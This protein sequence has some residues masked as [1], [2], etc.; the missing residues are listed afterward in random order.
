MTDLVTFEKF[1]EFWEIEPIVVIDS[2]SLLD[3]YRYAPNASKNI[4][5]NLKKIQDNIWLPAHVLEEYFEN[6]ASVISE[7]HKKFENVSKEVQRIVKD[8]EK[9]ITSKFYRYGKFKYPNISTFRNELEEI[10]SSLDEK[11]KSFKEIVTTEIQENKTVLQEDEV[12][13]FIQTLEGLNQIGVSFSLPKKIEIYREGEFRYSHLIPPGYK[14]IDKDSKDPTKTEKFGD[15]IIWK[16]LLDKS[17]EIQKPFI[18]ITDDEKEDWWELKVHNTHLGE[19]KEILGPR[20]ELVSEFNAVSKIGKD[21]FIMLTL[22]EFNKHISK[23]NEVNLKE[24]FLNDIELNPE[25]VVREIV[26]SKEWQLILDDS[27]ELTSSFIHDG[28]LQDLTGEIL[29]DVEITDFL[30]PEFDDLYVDYDEDEVII[31]G[32]FSCEV[33]V[34]IK[35]ALSS[36]YHEWI[37]SKLLLTGNITIEFNL[38]Y[39]EEKDAI[40]R[41][42]DTVAVSGITINNY[43]DLSIENDYSDIACISC[44]VRPGD[45]FTNEG[46]PVCRHCV[47][48]FD[49]CSGCGK[50][51]EPGTLGGY[52]CDNCDDD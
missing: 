48:K 11:A 10:I 14:D 51:F 12:N 4:L 38:K 43:E 34:N 9:D 13:S 23:V 50:L 27:G 7:A 1:K 37:E 24:V 33:I 8:V 3:L 21:G 16:E 29:T 39:D 47:D 20:K 19:R 15:L 25:E 35:T 26:D 30:N 46:D 49:V 42:D 2:C 52:K 41:L 28:E 5:E 6:K 44:G 22:P 40:E 17:T 45:H 36:E 32:S 18:F 31:E